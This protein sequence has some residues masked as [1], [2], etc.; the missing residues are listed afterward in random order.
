VKLWGFLKYLFLG[1][2]KINP[3]LCDG[4]LL[5]KILKEIRRIESNANNDDSHRNVINKIYSQKIQGSAAASSGEVPPEQP[6]IPPPPEAKPR[7]V[8]SG[9]GTE[10]P[11]EQPVT[12]PAQPASLLS[13]D[14]QVIQAIALGQRRQVEAE[15]SA[16]V[17]ALED[18]I[19]AAQERIEQE[20]NA[21]E[22][23][24]QE[25]AAALEAQERRFKLIQAA[26][27]ALGFG[28]YVPG[29]NIESAAVPTDSFI[30]PMSM[31]GGISGSD[32]VREYQKIFDDKAASPRVQVASPTG[33]VETQMDTRNL[34]SFLIDNRASL[35]KG[36]ENYA[37]NKLGLLRGGNVSMEQSAAAT[38][39]SNI[40]GAFLTFL[41]SEMRLTHQARFVLWQFCNN[42]VN[43]G[44]PPGQTA[45]VP[46]MLLLEEGD[47]PSD[48]HLLPGVPLTDQR[49]PLNATSE[50]I[51]IRENG[52]GRDGKV[53][54]VSIPE[55]IT[56]YSLMD[57]LTVLRQRLRYNY[58]LFEDISISNLWFQ[59]T[60][61]AYNNGG[62]MVLTPAQVT[63]NGGGQFTVDFLGSLAAYMADE[64]KVPPYDNCYG[65]VLNATQL[66]Q[67]NRD[68]KLNDRWYEGSPVNELTNYLAMETGQPIT[69]RV[70]G[71]VGMISNFHIF[72]QN[73]FGVG[74]PGSRGV[75]TETLGGT[76]RTTNTAFAFGMGT[77]GRAQALP[78][79]IR[80]II[81]NDGRSRDF[82]WLS[83]E[84]FGSLD[85]DSAI[86][87]GQQSRV[88]QVRTSKTKVGA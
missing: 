63:A 32:A 50:P 2:A 24:R 36:F 85:V 77:V 73:S 38:G 21:R 71:Y 65:L 20:A 16:K 27:N 87:P 56:A 70:S 53:R 47:V 58:E 30:A 43:L 55:F 62:D 4:L 42:R 52:V 37:K 69:G 13:D 81:V 19:T 12:P 14:E 60:I 45:S 3:K 6:I 64:L 5:V 31:R 18:Q 41:S 54:P 51:F 33:S 67:L 15:Y 79:N 46:R 39:F 88:I 29:L 84:G 86:S 7:V 23:V 10:A 66:E 83:H 78:F 61:T 72:R 25:S 80:E 8:G 34:D 49:Q 48:W 74:Q 17:K 22:Q 35:I 68:P 57:L 26:S 1:I 44:V 11:P 75:Q 40:P 76:P 82:Y 59:S 9:S 28:D